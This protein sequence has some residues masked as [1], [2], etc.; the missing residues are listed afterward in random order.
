MGP[1]D[2]GETIDPVTVNASSQS[3]KSDMGPDNDEKICT[4]ECGDMGD[5]LR[6][7]L[8]P[9][10]FATSG[11]DAVSAASTCKFWR[12]ASVDSP[13]KAYV[14]SAH[15]PQRGLFFGRFARAR[16]RV[17]VSNPLWGAHSFDK[18][19]GSSAQA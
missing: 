12:Q 9:Y 2:E 10:L 1:E 11:R 13:V 7:Y 4:A 5:F 8:F 19:G 18:E 15:R 6:A 14:R 3:V 16:K 17:C